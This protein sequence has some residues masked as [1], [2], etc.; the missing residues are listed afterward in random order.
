VT[1]HDLL[2]AGG[3]L[4]AFSMSTNARLGHWPGIA[5]YTKTTP[6]A[7]ATACLTGSL[8]FAVCGESAIQ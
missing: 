5:F 1:G 2:V 4:S 3:A 6:Q 8:P 7:C